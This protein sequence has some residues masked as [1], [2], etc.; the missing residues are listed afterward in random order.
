M[1]LSVVSSFDRIFASHE[2]GYRKPEREA[3]KIVSKAIAESP[4]S[5]VFFDDLR[6]N[7]EGALLVGF[8][9]VLVRAHAD[10]RSELRELGVE[11]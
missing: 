7:I 6:E 1:F 10:V 9:G 3:F 11:V 4:E 2:L 5:I 8:Q